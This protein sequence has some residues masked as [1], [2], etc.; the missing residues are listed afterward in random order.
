MCWQELGGNRPLDA[1][2]WTSLPEKVFFVQTN[3]I[4]RGATALNVV[5]IASD[6]I[7]E[8]MRKNLELLQSQRTANL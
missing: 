3:G 5:I 4:Y 7:E 8:L 1:S 2:A 6:I